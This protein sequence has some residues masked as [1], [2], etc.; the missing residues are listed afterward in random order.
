MKSMEQRV[1]EAMDEVSQ[2]LVDY[3]W[4][5]TAAALKGEEEQ[6]IAG[7]EAYRTLERVRKILLGL[8]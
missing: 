2:A 8:E 6:L 3:D 1:V 5:T 7:K 4:R